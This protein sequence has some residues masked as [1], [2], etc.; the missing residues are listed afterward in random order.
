[1]AEQVLNQITK[2][3]LLVT[4]DRN[5]INKKLI[6]KFFIDEILPNY[7]TDNY[8]FVHGAC[9]GADLLT[10]SVAEKL[11]Y[12]ILGDPANWEK[13]GRAA[14]PIRN[15]ELVR[16]LPSVV[17]VFHDDLKNSKGT[18]SCLNELAKVMKKNP[19]YNP[20]L[21]YNGVKMNKLSD[22]I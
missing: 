8:D 4:G 9:K 18:R 12:E 22:I 15:Q 21:Y 6:T 14:G 20:I 2:K 13:Y 7:P 5:Y 3:H 17:L 1:M 19:I 16:M 11:G 10:A